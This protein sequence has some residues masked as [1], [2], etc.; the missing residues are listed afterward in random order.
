[1]IKQGIK[2]YFKNLKHFFTPLGTTALGMMFGLSVLLPG[3]ISSINT[4]SLSIKAILQ[5]IEIDFSVLE[6]S[7][8]TAVRALDWGDPISSVRSI[9]SKSWLID[10]LNQCIG[11]L[12]GETDIYAAQISEAINIC[13]NQIFGYFIVFILFTILGMIGGYFLTKWIIQRNIAKT[14]TPKWIVTNIIDSLLSVALIV[15][16]LWLTS[17]WKPNIFISVIASVIIIGIV[18]L[19]EAYLLYA[20]N[21]VDIKQIVNLKN[22][23]KLFLTNI[24]ILLLSCLCIMVSILLTNVLVGLFVG[25][26]FIEIV[27]IVIDANAELYVLSL[28]EN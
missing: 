10:T 24:I 25:I 9:S 8:I 18:G 26:A 28:I 7:L 21:I 19:I 1:M 15:L 12:V 27:F 14:T 6:D 13:V 20:R 5:S 17:L 22:I 2:N 23:A 4:L 11:A 3:I 16:S